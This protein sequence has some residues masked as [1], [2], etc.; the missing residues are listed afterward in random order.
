MI[1]EYAA[2][3]VHHITNLISIEEGKIILNGYLNFNKK[4]PLNQDL[5]GALAKVLN[6]LRI[7]W[8]DWNT[9]KVDKT[10]FN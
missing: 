5:I 10:K 3:K 6:H 7:D 2:Y 4:F 9:F 8:L 1:E